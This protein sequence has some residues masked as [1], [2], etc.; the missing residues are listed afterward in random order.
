MCLWDPLGFPGEKFYK[1]LCDTW[2]S[3]SSLSPY[4]VEKG[5]LFFPPEE[6]L[7]KSRHVPN[8]TEVAQLQPGLTLLFTFSAEFQD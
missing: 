7:A 6:E 5:A 2:T 8:A 1:T 4:S 3:Q